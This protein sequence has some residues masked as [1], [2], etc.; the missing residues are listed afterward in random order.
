MSIKKYDPT[1]ITSCPVCKRPYATENACNHCD[2]PVDGRECPKCH[3]YYPK[4]EYGHEFDAIR[5]FGACGE[6]LG[7]CPYCDEEY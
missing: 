3:E 2:E 4:D 7:E 5:E 6:C 1:K